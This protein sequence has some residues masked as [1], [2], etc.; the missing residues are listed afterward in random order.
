MLHAIKVKRFSPIVFSDQWRAQLKILT[1]CYKVIYHLCN[2]W[3][4]NVNI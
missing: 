3:F 2:I 4:K 1:T